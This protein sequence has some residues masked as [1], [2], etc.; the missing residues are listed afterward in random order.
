[1]TTEEM[2]KKLFQLS[3]R[4]CYHRDHPNHLS[5]YYQQLEK[6]MINGRQ[7]Y[8]FDNLMEEQENFTLLKQ[9]RFSPVSTQE[10]APN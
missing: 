10:H 3:E 9:S 2:E 6:V 8:L 4:E 5:D 7:V 1:M